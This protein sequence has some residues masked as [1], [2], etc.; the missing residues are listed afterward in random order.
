LVMFIPVQRWMNSWNCWDNVFGLKITK[1]KLTF[2][3][4]LINFPYKLKNWWEIVYEWRYLKAVE[5]T[6][7]LRRFSLWVT[8]M[9][10]KVYVMYLHVCMHTCG[11]ACLHVRVFCMGSRVHIYIYIYI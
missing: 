9:S 11:H 5:N 6:G 1:G 3:I 8:R 7:S 2:S 4:L 10:Y